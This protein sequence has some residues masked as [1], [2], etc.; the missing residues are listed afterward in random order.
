M[1][2]FLAMGGYAPYIWISYGIAAA[3]M[4]GLLIAT[5]RALR[6]RERTLTGLEA[7]RGRRR[8]S[9]GEAGERQP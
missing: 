4:V 1:S 8:R 7:L 3:V 9:P 5:L 2:E 6:F